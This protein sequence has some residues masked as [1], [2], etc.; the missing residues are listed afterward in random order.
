MYRQADIH[1]HKQTYR[2]T[3]QTGRQADR[4]ASGQATGK[5]DYI[6]S[7]NDDV[8]KNISNRLTD[9]LSCK[10]LVGVNIVKWKF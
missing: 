5:Q 1:A 6:L 9:V 7:K 3:I 2:C 4:W 10:M 8:T